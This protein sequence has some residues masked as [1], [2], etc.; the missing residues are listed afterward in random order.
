MMWI[1]YFHVPQLKVNTGIKNLHHQSNKARQGIHPPPCQGG[2]HFL[3]S[4]Y[5][6]VWPV[7]NI[8][9][10]TLS[11]CVYSTASVQHLLSAP[12]VA[13]FSMDM[14]RNSKNSLSIN[15]SC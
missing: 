14:A 15:I 6:A 10:T 12:P 2:R 11:S 13:I 5:D 3:K 1:V 4:C 9:S 7:S 8:W